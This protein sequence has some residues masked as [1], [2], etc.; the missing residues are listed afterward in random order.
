MEKQL[1]ESE[2]RYFLATQG[3]NDGL[4]DWDVPQKKI[5]FSPRWKSMLGYSDRQIGNSP[6]DWFS[7]IHPGDKEQVERLL[8]QHLNGTSSHFE[9]EYR[10]LDSG[11]EYR[12]VLCRGLA[13][14]NEHG[15]AYRFA[16]SQ[17]DITDRKVYNPL[18]GL[19]NQIL[20][21]DRLDHAFK[22]AGSPKKSFGVAVIEV[23]GLK[24]I[25][26]S[27]G[28]V[29]ADRLLCLL[30]KTIQSNLSK[31]DTVAHLGN[32][33][34][35]LIL[36]DT[37]DGKQAA[38]A[39]SRLQQ[40]LEQPIHLEG[41][42]VCISAFIGIAL[43]NGE[44]TSA[45]E[46]MRDA[47][48]AMQR[49]KDGGNGRFEIFDRDMRAS[50]VKRLNLEA[51]V[52]KAFENNEFRIHYQPIVNLRNGDLAGF[53]AL[54]RWQNKDTL[55]YPEE[56]LTMAESSDLLVPLEKWVLRDACMQVSRWIDTFKAA[57]T[58]NVNLSPKH[59]ANPQ[60]IG[61]LYEALEKS[62]LKPSLLRLEITE[63]ALMDSTEAVAYTLAK[64]RDMDVQLHMD[65]FGTGYSSLSYLNRFPIDSLKVD[66]S[67]VAKLGLCEETW[68]IVQAIVSL[69]QNLD[70][71]LI[72]EGIENVMQLRMLQTLKCEYGQGYYF[73]K[74][75]SAEETEVLISGGFPWKL[76]FETNPAT[77]ILNLAVEAS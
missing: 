75:I 18:T 36:E 63:S 10:I 69:G 76:A 7:R 61:L 23:S 62:G 40:K 74:P 72:A 33:D 71:E 58:L 5:Y 25:A 48:T 73:S 37:N 54:L 39:A 29:F 22:R 26:S 13:R 21:M 65:D 15:E 19:P 46:L 67:F 32:D 68:K 11:G 38:V 52:R 64:I 2:E 53:E 20:F 31:D 42:S 70:K 17:T 14:R 59:Y 12:W 27:F 16:G 51:D 47:Y 8:N 34:F 50:V 35:A 30:S 28:Y 77:R 6:T 4:W 55:M 45:D 1:R 41:Q 44:C 43:L 57:F 56:F 49:A 9:T 24:E 66:R 3:A 60:L